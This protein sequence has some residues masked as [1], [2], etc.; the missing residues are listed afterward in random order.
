MAFVFEEKIGEEN[1]FDK[2][3]ADARDKID[4]GLLPFRCSLLYFAP[5]WRINGGLDAWLMRYGT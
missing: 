1:I 4:K 5:G 2:V 3:K